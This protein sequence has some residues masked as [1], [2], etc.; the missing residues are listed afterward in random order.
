MKHRPAKSSSFIRAISSCRAAVAQLLIACVLFQHLALPVYAYAPRTQAAAVARAGLASRA[1]ATLH[2]LAIGAGNV[3]AVVLAHARAAFAPQENWNIVLTPLNTEFHNHTGLDHHQ[4]GNKLILSAAPHNFELVGAD[5]SHTPFSNVSGLGGEV[6]L[7][8]TRDAGQGLS[9]G[10]F[11]AGELFASVGLPGVVARLSADGATFQNPWVALPNE[12]GLISGLHA[13]RTG[14]F[15]GDLVVATTAGGVWR[16]NSAATPTRIA[17]LNTRLAGVTVIPNDPVKYGPW[18]GRILVGAPDASAIYAVDAQGNATSYDLGLAPQD[19]R[20][21]PAH[22]NF[23]ALDPAG[24]KIWGA[25]DDAFAGIIGDVLVA[26]GSPGVLARVHWDGA[27]FE[28]GRLAEVASLEQT[29]FSPAGLAEIAEVPRRYDAIAIVRHAPNISGGGRV[30]GAIWQQLAENISLSGNSVITSDLLVPGTPR[31]NL[32]GHPNFAGVIQGTGNPQPSTHALSMSGNA[33][34]RHLVTR[35]NPVQWETVAPPP[36]PAGTRDLSLS[37]PNQPLGDPATLRHLSLSGKAGAVSIP[38]GTYGRF[39]GSGRDTAFVLGVAGATEPSAYN[40]E[41][42]SLSGGSELR[43]AGPVVLMLKGDVSISGTAVGAANDPRR[44][45]IRVATGGVSLSGG[46]VLYGVVSAP[47]GTISISGQARLRGTVACDRLTVTGGGILQIT[48]NMLPPPPVNRPPAVDAGPAHTITLPTNTTS[49]AGS[50]SDDGLP[51]GSTLSVIWTKVSGPGAVT[52]ADPHSAATSATFG[53][54]GEYVLKLTASDGQLSSSDTTTVTV[55]SR[56]QPPTVDAGEAQTI[57]LPAGAELRGTV[58]DDALPSGSNVTSTWSVASGPGT[59]AFAD[60]HVVATTATFGGP[61]VY[62]LRLCASDTELTACDEVVITVL[63]NEPPVVNAGPDLEVTLPNVAALN[64]MATDDGLPRGSALEVSWS[65]ASGPG[66]VIFND[67]FATVTVATFTTPGTYVLRLTANDSQLTAF[68][69]A[70]IVVKPQ[71]FTARTYTLDA[72]FDEGNLLNLTHSTP[73]QL[74]LDSTTQTLNFIWVAVS[75]KGTAVKINTETGAIIGEYFTS[76]NGQPRDPSRT[77]VDQNGNVWATNR[78]GNSV[79]HIGLVENGQCV[80]RNNNGQID[81]STGFGDIRAWTNAGGA[82]TNGGVSTAADECIIH[83]TKVNSFGTRHVSVNKDNDIWVS[84][85]SGQRFDLIDGRTGL[86]KRSEPS[87]GYGG[88]GGL[89]DRNGVIWSANPMLRW[90][91]SKPLTGPNAVS[92]MAF[93]LFGGRATWD[94]AGKTS[95]QPAPSEEVWVEDTTPEGASLFGDGEGWNWVNTNPTPF[96]GTLAH[97]SNLVNGTHQHYFQNAAETLSV[98]VGDNLFTYVYLDPANPPSQVMLQWNNG[99]WEHRAYWGQNQIP[100]GA[101]GTESRR[102]MGPLPAPGQWARL[103][104][105]ASQVGLEGSGTNWRGYS[106][107][108]YGLCI[109]SQGNVFNTTYGNGTIRKFAPDGT[110]VGTFNQGASFSQGCVVDRNDHV[111]IAHSLNNSTVG[112]MKND[113]T[114]VGTILVGSGPTGVAVDGAGKVWATN[115]NSRTVSRIDPALGPLGPDGVTRIGAV[116]FT[117]RDL[118]GNPYNYSDMTGSTLTAAPLSGTWTT[119]F[120]SH[121]AGAEWGRIGWAAQVCGDASLTVSV[122]SSENGTTFG[123]G[124]TVSNG[125]DP[126]VANGRYLRV[127]VNFRRASSGESPVLYDLSV[128]T[129]GYTLPV[130]ENAAPTVFAGADKSVT[131][132]DAVNLSGLSCDDGFPRGSALALTWAKVSGPG[133]VTFTRPNASVTDATFSAPGEYLLRLTASDSAETVSDEV[134]VTVLP[135]NMAPIVNAGPDQT[136]TLPNTATMTGT[137]SDDGLPSGGTLTT[138]WSQLSGP[139]A[140]NFDDP[141]D[142]LARAVFPVAGTYTLRLAGNDSHRI[143]TDDIVITVNPSPALVGAT[144]ALAADAPGP[145]VTGTTQTLRA[146]LKNSAGNPLANYGVEFT[147]VGPNA[148]SGS[149]VTNSAGVATFNYSGTNA[150]TDSVSALV[151]STS[152]DSINSNAVAMEWTLTPTSPPTTQGWIGGPLDGSTATGLVPVTVGAGVTLTEAKVEYWPAGDPSAVT[153]LTQNAQGGPG[154]TLATLDTT[155]LANGNYVIRLTATEANGQQLVSQVLITVAGDNKPGRITVSVTDLT[156]PMEGLPITVGRIYDSLE[157]NTVGDFGHGWSLTLGSPRLEVSP[158]NDVTI[159]EPGTGRRITFNFAPTSFG[160]P[161]SFFYQPA[162]TPEP[163]VFGKLTTDGCGML[164]RAGAQYTCFLSAEPGFRP[165]TYVY[166]DPYGRVYTMAADG[167]LRSIKTL[168]GETLT[169]SPTGITSSEGGLSVPFVRDAQGR[170]TQVTD[171]TGKVYNY[172]YDAAG[173]LR[174]VAL[175]GLS[176]PLAYE[177]DASHYLT[178]STDARGNPEATNAY[179]P[180]GRLQSIT[181]A[182]GETTSYAYDLATHTTRQTNPDGGVVRLN[183]D[184][185]GVLLSE[186]DAL[187]HTKSYTY[188]ANRNKL[189]ETDALGQTT[190]FTYD[191]GGNLTSRT[192][193]QGRATRATYNQ[194]GLP[195]TETD[196]LG[197]VKTVAYD[198]SFNPVAVRDALGTITSFTV[199]SRGNPLTVSDGTGATTRFTYDAYGRQLTVTDPLGRT[200]AHTYDGMGRVLTTTDARGGVMRFTYD[201]LGRVLSITEPGTPTTI[202]YVASVATAGG[203]PAAQLASVATSTFEYDGNG[204]RTTYTDALGRVTAYEYDAANRLTEINYADGTS[205]SFTYDFRGQKLTETDQLGRTTRYTYDLTGQ[206]VKVRYADGGEVTAT[207]DELERVTTV[208]D[209]R[210][211]T[212]RYEHDPACGCT[213]RVTKITD[214]LGRVTQYRMDAAG[215]LVGF[216]DS[217]GRERTYTYD[218]RNRVTQVN[219]PDGTTVKQSYDGAGRVLASEDQEGRVSRFGYDA[220]GNLTS[221]I[222]ALNQT[223]TYGYDA[224]RNIVSHTDANGRTTVFE[225]DASSRMTKRTLPLGMFETFG[226]DAVGNVVSRVDQRG[227]LTTYGYDLL[228]RLVRKTPDLTLGDAPVTYAYTATGER[229]L[230][231]DASGATTYAYDNRDRLVSK[232]TPQGTLNYTYDAADNLLSMQSPGG[233]SVTYTY[234]ALNRLATVTDNRLTEGTTNYNYDEVG[235]LAGDSRPN[236][237]RSAYTYNSVNRLTNVNV[238]R[239]ASL[240][241]YAYTVTP[242]GRRL[243]S[244][245]Q[246]GRNTT[247]SYDPLYRLTGETVS[248]SNPASNGSVGYTYDAVGNRTARTSTMPALPAQSAGYDANDRVTTNAY[249]ATGSERGAEGRS[250]AYDFENR[251]KS[252][253]GGGVRLVYDGDGN[254][255]AKTVGGV[256]TR[257]LVDDLN[258]TGYSQVVGEVVGAQVQRT[259]TYGHL[260]INQNRATEAGVQTSFYGYDGHGNVRLLTDSSG[261]VTDTYDYDAFGN[262]VSSTGSTPNAYL[263]S[264]E[265]YDADLGLYHLRARHYNPRQGRFTSMDPFAGYA[266]SPQTLHKY[267]YVHADPVNFIDPSGLASSSEYRVL[268]LAAFRATP[269]MRRL[270]DAIICV[271]VHVASVIAQDPNMPLPP[272]L[273]RFAICRCKVVPVGIIVDIVGAASGGGGLSP[274]NYPNPDPPMS[275]PPVRYTPQNPDEVRRMRSGRGPVPRSD[276]PD[277]QIAPHHRQQVPIDSG[278]VMDEIT[279]RQHTRDGNHTRHNRPSSLTD[280]Q[281]KREIRRHWRGRGWQYRLPGECI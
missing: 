66:P 275:E 151:R 5:G 240:A 232:Q 16:V 18:A 122:A 138:F 148:T 97:Q 40:L 78:A 109:D 218:E 171:P 106:H 255:A 211:N 24:G 55:I 162:Y 15:A 86:I 141:S 190:R 210:G 62:T 133:E 81:T 170:I 39:T 60:P 202:A 26:Q 212:T 2:Q 164:I 115:Y 198:S 69:E 265:R 128:G 79:V 121:V 168:S 179:Y 52:F 237:V 165:T 143:G 163:G 194:F 56:N 247:Y 112:H 124:V 186:T 54:A 77:T 226:Y 110:L 174:A 235:N 75:T 65:V 231:T 120:D 108:S 166:T 224:T 274:T 173:D 270:S 230:M 225:Y 134:T 222:D 57:E 130:P 29:T 271:F 20:L 260:L 140:V 107:P 149:G 30:E 216:I 252:A 129:A 244:A 46:A 261:A 203:P 250:F 93:T 1:G 269:A 113:G 200:T 223:T 228:D 241:N 103:E 4:P 37:Q 72:D 50:A 214:A 277:R 67:A 22:E 208:T 142:P 83:Y 59:V 123:P 159:T 38:P 233:L 117:T 273:A 217:A 70:T 180:D 91:T 28:V 253:D 9:L 10:G 132:P 154:A 7:T 157:R 119:T 152:T 215:K 12:I 99:S 17:T 258:P 100:F 88:Y 242:T 281:R 19:I 192:D 144:L 139:A 111:W 153:V 33:S 73:N 221:V 36:V 53:S 259:Y 64:G 80:D 48:E 187:G 175:P 178:K 182:L 278:G 94:R 243:T 254:L 31:L 45:T 155:L 220:T 87:V 207:R 251:M 137:V 176:N 236:G 266:G 98:G 238:A 44:V 43:L 147:V 63:K 183:Y 262:L 196:P 267:T 114:Y 90:D 146:T 199:D 74:Q 185:A 191:A 193:A 227:K 47:S 51:A 209:E 204:N 229:A 71:P 61:G 41:A 181:N 126:V 95:T 272:S 150:G 14:V 76:P 13:D 85:T 172:T 197:N 34:L 206:L 23:Y 145:Y 280:G 8:T 246:N 219:Y 158:D 104:V 249:D 279:E 105:P 102:H 156:V 42:L 118:G 169:F 84:G 127:S 3:A 256:T 82:D 263:Y 239:A 167:A 49:L 205:E 189:T 188:D 125:D 35:T 68:D 213:N 184:A 201:A 21:I 234:D 101:D 6:L 116:D 136:I 58:A 268:T 257:Y 131:M 89:I 276:G 11:R 25:P 264:G 248:G 135:P 160:F 32:S 195:L 245:E 92:G 177:Y 96:S 27:A 161:F